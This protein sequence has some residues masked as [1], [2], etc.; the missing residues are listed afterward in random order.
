[1][2]QGSEKM[3]PI[4]SEY[5]NGDECVE[6]LCER[7]GLSKSQFYYWHRKYQSTLDEHPEEPNGFVPMIRVG[8]SYKHELETPG[9]MIFRS[10]D[11]LPVSYVLELTRA[12]C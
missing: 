4:V 3:F 7:Y 9:G 5:L 1:M 6:S 11:L 2:R 10:H 8:G 12:G